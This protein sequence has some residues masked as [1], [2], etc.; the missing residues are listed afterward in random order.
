MASSLDLAFADPGVR[1]K[2]LSWQFA[3][4]LKAVAISMLAGHLVGCGPVRVATLSIP[5]GRT[6]AE[7][8]LDEAECVH[9]S[10]PGYVPLLFGAGVAIRRNLMKGRYAD[11]MEG[12][13]YV[14][15]R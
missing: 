7:Q 5:E 11:C 6:L 14:V 12:K 1:S 10:E 3:S 9:Y 2:A 8:Q 13:G 4:L 15:A